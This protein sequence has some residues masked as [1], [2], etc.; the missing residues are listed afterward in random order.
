MSVSAVP[1][2]LRLFAV[3]VFAW[4]AVRDFR[5]RRIPNRIWKPLLV[6]G[7][8]ALGA[9]GLFAWLS[10]GFVWQ[11]FLVGTVV[12][13]GL[14]VPLG[15]GFWLIGAFGG[16]DAKAVMVLAVL[17]PTVPTYRL[18]EVVLPIVESNVGA[19]GLTILTN[20]VVVAVLYPLGL[21]LYNLLRGNLSVLMLLGRPVEI[22]RLSHHHG[23]MLETPSGWTTA[24]LDL[25]ALRMYL[26]WRELDIDE[27]R[28]RTTTLRDPAS[29]P[30]E[31][32]PPTDGAVYR[33]DGGDPWGAAEFLST[34]DHDAYGTDPETLRDGLAVIADP[35]REQLWVSP[36]IPFFIP[37]FIGL[38]FGLTYGDLLFSALRLLGLF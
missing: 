12:S 14:L 30:D 10:G 27:L 38:L 34:I 2:I 22:A 5:T 28:R 8:V 20:A 31:P 15:Y 13:I 32:A 35:D 25:D 21:G 19:F 24:G 1:D 3:P 6:L 36:G 11:Q 23:R 9:E 18:G 4:A 26:R 29:L 17:F 7:G 37:L 33:S 16:A